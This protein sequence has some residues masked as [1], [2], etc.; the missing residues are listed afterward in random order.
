MGAAGAEQFFLSNTQRFNTGAA[1]MSGLF[2]LA[3]HGT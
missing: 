3:A 1:Q 2:V